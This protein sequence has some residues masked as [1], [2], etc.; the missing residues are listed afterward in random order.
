MMGTLQWRLNGIDQQASWSSAE[1]PMLSL[2]TKA[3][4][5]FSNMAATPASL[6][7]N[8]LREVRLAV[9]VF[10]KADKI[11]RPTS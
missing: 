8:I 2:P 7:R 4:K 6:Y 5:Y 9:R 11:D 3:T 10:Q 1:L